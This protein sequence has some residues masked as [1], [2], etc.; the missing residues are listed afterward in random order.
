VYGGGIELGFLLLVMN[1]ENLG[2]VKRGTDEWRRGVTEKGTI[3]S[4]QSIQSTK[5]Q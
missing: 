4:I 2:E 1:A 5:S 3:Q